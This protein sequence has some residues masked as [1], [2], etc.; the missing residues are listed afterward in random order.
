VCV[1]KKI[2]KTYNF[3]LPQGIYFLRPK[4]SGEAKKVVKVK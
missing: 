1:W 2:V 4:D 3:D